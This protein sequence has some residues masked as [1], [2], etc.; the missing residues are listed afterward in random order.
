MVHDTHPLETQP[1][2]GKLK[3]GD[4][5][6][7]FTLPDQNNRPVHFADVLGAN[8]IVL[9]FYPKDFTGGCTMEACAFRDSY[10]VFKGAGADVI[11]VSADSPGTHLEFARTHRLPFTLLSDERSTVHRLYGVEKMLG[12]FAGRVTFIIDKHG[13]IRHIF[14]SRI[15]I[16]GHITDALAVI[17][18]LQRASD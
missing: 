1:H 12:L 14:S 6:P 18:S 3:V 5:A 10:E 11:G 4:R 16:P 15:N 9:Y 7:D 13:I 8:T 17:Q 2:T